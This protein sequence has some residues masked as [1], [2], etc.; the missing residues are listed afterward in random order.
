MSVSKQDYSPVSTSILK[1]YGY[2]MIDPQLFDFYVLI[3][4]AKQTGKRL[5]SYAYKSL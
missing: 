1:K 4:F 3:F 5:S 2:I